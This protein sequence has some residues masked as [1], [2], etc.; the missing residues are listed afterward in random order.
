MK[1][2]NEIEKDIEGI[3]NNKLSYCPEVKEA[4]IYRVHRF[5]VEELKGELTDYITE[6]YQPKTT[7]TDIEE[8]KK[9]F[10]KEAESVKFG[11]EFD[12]EEIWNF[13]LPHLSNKSELK[14]EAVKEGE[15]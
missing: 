15:K 5:R 4:D 10:E 11:F 13:F 1:P 8:L 7:S 6:N 2:L 3:I 14:K 12:K 9:E